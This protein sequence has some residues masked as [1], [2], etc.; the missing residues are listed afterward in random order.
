MTVIQK[1]LIIDDE[2]A[3]Q[4]SCNQVLKREGYRVQGATN[5]AEGL[6]HFKQE[7]FHVVLLDL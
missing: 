4:D 7:T 5:G 2:E 3:I 1:I 6:Q